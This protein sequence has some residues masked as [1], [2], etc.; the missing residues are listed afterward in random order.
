[1]QLVRPWGPI[2]WSLLHPSIIAPPGKCCHQDN[3]G[4]PEPRLRVECGIFPIPRRGKALQAGGMNTSPINPE[5]GTG[6]DAGMSAGT[7]ADSAGAADAAGTSAPDGSASFADGATGAQDQAGFRT[8]SMPG[9]SFFGPGAGQ[10][11]LS[12]P[13]DDRMLAG[14]ASGVARYLSVDVTLVRIVLAV[15]VFVGGAGVP[16]YLAGWLLIPEDGADRSIAS[17]LI[18]S[19]E[20]RSR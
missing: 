11:E 6:T 20:N 1:M 14:V 15:L 2:T 19:L 4:Y 10:R 18:G 17:D 3:P 12:R 13:V 7:S 5:P 8:A 16:I 9:P